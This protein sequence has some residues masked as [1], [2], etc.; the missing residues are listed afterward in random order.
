MSNDPIYRKFYIRQMIKIYSER[1]TSSWLLEGDGRTGKQPKG[2]RNDH[3]LFVVKLKA[4]LL[5][6]VPFILNVM[7]NRMS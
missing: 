4:C 2:N 3:V 6:C 5:N 1:K 7:T